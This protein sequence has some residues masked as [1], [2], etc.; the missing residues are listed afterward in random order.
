MPVA[1][2]EV[3]ERVER[4]ET[5]QDRRRRDM[6]SRTDIAGSIALLTPRENLPDSGEPSHEQR[7]YVGRQKATYVTA[8]AI[9]PLHIARQ[10]QMLRLRVIG[11]ESGVRQVRTATLRLFEQ[12][13]ARRNLPSESKSTS[14]TLLPGQKL[15]VTKEPFTLRKGR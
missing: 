11:S 5:H 8:P 13:M 15:Q 3:P 14:Q 6:S 9:I 1:G 2:E 4:C 10:D 7:H 12:E